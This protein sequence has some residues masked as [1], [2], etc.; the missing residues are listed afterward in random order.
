MITNNQNAMQLHSVSKYQK[1]GAFSFPDHLI[2]PEKKDKNWH[3]ECAEAI[4]SEYLRDQTATHFSTRENFSE[5][6]AYGKGRQRVDDYKD[7]LAVDKKSSQKR[8]G[9]MN[10]DWS[11]VPIILKYK[12]VIHGMFNTIEHD[13]DAIATDGVSGDERFDQKYGDYY[14]KKLDEILKP[15]DQQMGVEDPFQEKSNDFVPDTLEELEIWEQMGSFKLKFETAIEKMINH[16]LN[17]DSD[18]KSLK[19]KLLEDLMDLNIIAT[20]SYVDPVSQK[21][22][23]RYVDPEYLIIQKSKTYDF[24]D[25]EF[26]GE[27]YKVPLS[28]IVATGEFKDEELKTIQRVNDGVNSNNDLYPYEY[29]EEK[30][31]GRMND[32]KVLVMDCEIITTDRKYNE[33]RKTKR[34]DK[35]IH[36]AE[37]GK[38]TQK[39]NRQTKVKDVRVVRKM[40]W[41]VGT[42]LVYDWGLQN[43]VPRQNGTDPLLS[44]NVYKLNGK[45]MI[46]K[47]IPFI[48][49]FQLTYLKFQN[50]LMQMK[51]P[52][53]AIE[54]SA[55][56]NISL[57]GK[58][59]S[60]KELLTIKRDTGDL[61][62]KMTTHRG[63]YTNN[64]A[65]P[66]QELQG[67]MGAQ[68]QEYITMFEHYRREISDITGVTPQASASEPK[69]GVGLGVSN[70]AL[71]GTS[72]ALKPM[73]DAYT[74]CKERT[75]LSLG[76]R[77][78]ILLSYSKRAREI[79]KPILGE[80]ATEVLGMAKE[81]SLRQ[82]G[83]K[84][85]VRPTEEEKTAVIQSAQV[86]LQAGKNGEPGITMSD[87]ILITRMVSNGDLRMAEAMI[88]VRTEKR[89]K[90]AIQQSQQTVKIQ[91]EENKQLEQLK[92]QAEIQKN[93]AKTEAELAVIDRKYQWEEKL[94]MMKLE[95][96]GMK[97]GAEQS[98]QLMNKMIDAEVS[99]GDQNT[100]QQLP[101]N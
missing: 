41:I 86:A 8:K 26:A 52:G 61:L 17:E 69:A 36:D 21:I 97:T 18:W 81:L 73:M 84:L 24:R 35:V 37:F 46:E 9:Y 50:S 16:A 99:N 74:I 39:E 1:S 75:S 83:I 14:R 79:Y 42:D 80:T 15:L 100:P 38:V 59:M 85:R 95:A 67:G 54:W 30:D 70:I 57:G 13:V 4:Y 48:D 19:Y 76:L 58:L 82:L 98:N 64:G 20:K 34:G 40:K 7:R 6:R 78:Q 43:D 88:H 10:V 56:D 87:F 5:F 45:S 94:L 77:A 96:E 65:K 62:Y 33:I 22:K 66:F 44:F 63:N 23:A 101:M 2:D 31:R 92:L 29:F 51:N 27:L 90:E 32:Y 72:N 91:A 89:K 68:L 11:V 47:C 93:Q 71:L 25:S 49:Q 12:Q 3:K 55:L 53:I 28:K 60:P